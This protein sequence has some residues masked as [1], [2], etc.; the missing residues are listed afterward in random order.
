MQHFEAD[1][2]LK[3]YYEDGSEV[4]FDQN[5]PAI[6]SLYG[7][8]ARPNG[9]ERVKNVS[10]IVPVNGSEIIYYPED[11]SYHSRVAIDDNTD[12][13]GYNGV[14][15]SSWD[16]IGSGREYIGALAFVASGNSVSYT[17]Q[18]RNYHGATGVGIATIAS[19]DA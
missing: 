11:G 19:V 13:G 4:V 3:F 17:E 8:N 1:V 12:E 16:Q 5:K 2:T 15:V 9:N 14:A 10:G 6:F 18:H 7:I